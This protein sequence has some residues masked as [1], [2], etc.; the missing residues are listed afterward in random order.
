MFSFR[1][2]TNL[3]HA[4]LPVSFHQFNGAW[5]RLVCRFSSYDQ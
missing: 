3:A 2:A 1:L 4:T 5:K